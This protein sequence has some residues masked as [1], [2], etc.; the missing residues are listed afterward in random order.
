MTIYWLDCVSGNDTN[1]G[2][3]PS[4]A[5]LTAAPLRALNGNTGPA[6]GSIIK[7]RG[8][9]VAANDATAYSSLDMR[10]NS[11]TAAAKTTI[12]GYDQAYPA[13]WWCA[14]KMVNATGT[15]GSNSWA[16]PNAGTYPDVWQVT[17]NTAWQGQQWCFYW[18]GNQGRAV[19]NQPIQLHP[20]DSPEDVNTTVNSFFVDTTLTPT[21]RINVSGLG[22][23]SPSGRILHGQRG[24]AL[25]GIRGTLSLFTDLQH[26]LFAD[27]NYYQCGHRTWA[28]GTKTLQESGCSNVEIRRSGFHF[29]DIT[30]DHSVI[31]PLGRAGP[32]VID[33]SV[34]EGGQD[35]LMYA[36]SGPGLATTIRG[37]E[38]HCMTGWHMTR[39]IMR[40][41]GYFGTG[42]GHAF[43]FLGSGKNLYV[44]G[45]LIDGCVRSVVV[46]ANPARSL[47]NAQNNLTFRRNNIINTH[48]A[49]SIAAQS[50]TTTAGNVQTTA[51][52]TEM[53]VTLSSS[54]VI[55]AGWSVTIATAE[56]VG[57]VA[58]A[59]TFVVSRRVSST[60]FYVRL[61]SAA[62][63]TANSALD[64]GV[65]IA[66]R[67]PDSVQAFSIEG[68]QDINQDFS[69]ILVDGCVI[70][71][72]KFVPRSW[73]E[74]APGIPL[75]TSATAYR[76]TISPY[77][78]TALR[79]AALYDTPTMRN[80]VVRNWPLGIWSTNADPKRMIFEHSIIIGPRKM[81]GTAY[82]FVS[83][84]RSGA[85][86]PEFVIDYNTYI[87]EVFPPASEVPQWIIT[88]GSAY[89]TLATW[90]AQAFP[91]GSGLNF[92]D[93]NSTLV[94][95]LPPSTTLFAD[96]GVTTLTADDG[97]TALIAA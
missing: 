37:V 71:P 86:Y 51:G 6:G 14:G 87:T 61:A 80:I 75:L 24:Y 95:L 22:A 53:L 79:M 82:G 30:N 73:S 17:L 39:N 52:S 8:R 90:Q 49:G 42:D 56:T 70:D 40:Q 4:D 66:A 78:S 32:C 44:A 54:A 91:N 46:W 63:S 59:G 60:A 50:H 93:L 94:E 23:T 64:H 48:D 67:G 7:M 29:C 16:R 97:T 36:F 62:V 35:G 72:P 11:G 12:R 27:F 76:G 47:P 89:G 34:I 33:R 13:D 57:G 85:S 3:G 65:T 96:D 69:G 19:T 2:T 20:V 10:V 74:T 88:G 81:G 92:P 25:S 41:C 43:G 28:I 31:R 5:W 9:L 18:N 83:A 84:H 77:N 15:L 55:G 58:V 68:G 45:N 38:G 1:G 21:I 26:V